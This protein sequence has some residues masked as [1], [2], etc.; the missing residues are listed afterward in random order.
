MCHGKVYEIPKIITHLIVFN[1]YVL[2][3]VDLWLSVLSSS[4][5][6]AF[7]SHKY[8]MTC[9]QKN[10]QIRGIHLASLYWNQNRQHPMGGTNVHCMLNLSGKIT[11]HT[12]SES[13]TLYL[14][15][16]SSAKPALNQYQ[17]HH[18]YQIT[19]L[20]QTAFLAASLSEDWLWKTFTNSFP[21]KYLWIL[22]Y[23][24]YE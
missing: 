18:S 7:Y 24:H 2:L 3:T 8:C 20:S 4:I 10:K 16:Q 1:H 13:P 9:Y 21:I 19:D 14:Q 15:L 6:K 11:Q 23:M 5:T 22:H 12:I 17:I